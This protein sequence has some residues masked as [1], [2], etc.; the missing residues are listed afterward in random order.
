MYWFCKEEVAPYISDLQQCQVKTGFGGNVGNK[1]GVFI[2]FNLH[3]TSMIFWCA[4]LKSGQESWVDRIKNLFE[5]TNQA[6]LE[7]DNYLFFNHDIKFFFGDLNFRIEKAHEE[8]I[9][10]LKK[11]NF[12]NKKQKVEELLLCDQL[13]LKKNELEW[14]NEYKEMPI[15]FLPT[16]RF[17]S[18]TNEYDVIKKRTPSWWD[19]IMWHW[20][21]SEKYQEIG[22]IITPLEYDRLETIFGDHKP[23]VA[24][25]RVLGVN[26]EQTT[27]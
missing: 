10:F 4:H 14:L 19:R 23:V 3:D 12:H 17:K 9:E 8:T 27:K 11:V 18:N 15:T 21:S 24:Y 20:E 2:R 26:F 25:F 22:N 5:I 6:F 1:G 16:Y 13:L 7:D